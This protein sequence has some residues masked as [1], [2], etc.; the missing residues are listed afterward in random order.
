[1]NIKPIKSQEDY[2]AVLAEI[3]QLMDAQADTL[4]GDRLD[5]VTTLAQSY[6]AKNYSIEEPDPIEAILHR[7]EALE[8]SR[9]DLEP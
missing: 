5:I 1:M 7:M 6:E 4:E 3:D 9:K 8:L 2:E